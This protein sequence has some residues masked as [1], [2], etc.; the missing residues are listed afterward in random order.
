MNGQRLRQSVGNSSGSTPELLRSLA[1][2]FISG[3]QF[4][5]ARA[6]IVDPRRSSVTP[7]T[8]Q[9]YG[10]LLEGPDR[11]ARL[12]AGR[13]SRQCCLTNEPKWAGEVLDVHQSDR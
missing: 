7:A 2:G 12:T 3:L 11:S 8:K 1:T 9:A 6:I 13:R 4:R 10:A 5:K